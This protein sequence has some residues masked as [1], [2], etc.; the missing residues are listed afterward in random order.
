[1]EPPDAEALHVCGACSGRVVASSFL[2]AMQLVLRSAAI[3]LTQVVRG[4]VRGRG[5]SKCLLALSSGFRALSCNQMRSP[6]S[7]GILRPL[8][9][10]HSLSACTRAGAKSLR[11]SSTRRACGEGGEG[12]GQSAQPR[13]F[14]HQPRQL[15]TPTNLVCRY[16]PRDAAQGPP[17]LLHTRASEQ[18][19]AASTLV[20]WS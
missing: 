19:V 9:V 12:G 5:S 16:L 4:C 1:M 14:L 15:H 20:A 8:D 2:V 10:T 3:P 11:C 13:G 17:V 6:S 7:V 18:Q